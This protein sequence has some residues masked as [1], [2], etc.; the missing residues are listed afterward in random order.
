MAVR[1]FGENGIGD[2]RGIGLTGCEVGKRT[3]TNGTMYAE[4]ETKVKSRK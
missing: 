3:G 2:G 4:G 1:D